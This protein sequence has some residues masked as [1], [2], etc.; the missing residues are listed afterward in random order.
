MRNLQRIAVLTQAGKVVGVYVPPAPATD[1][2]TPV[3]RIVAG[4]RQQIHEVMA[5]VP[6]RL[7]RS[8]DVEAFHAAVRKLLK[9]GKRRR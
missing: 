4:P 6:A 9:K 1:S 2:R 3:A 8:K 5:E 7:E